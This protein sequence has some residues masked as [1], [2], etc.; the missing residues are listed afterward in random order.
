MSSINLNDYKLQIPYVQTIINDNMESGM[1]LSD[2]VA[3]LSAS[4]H[5]PL[6]ATYS[7]MALQMGNTPEIESTIESLKTF[8]HVKMV[9]PFEI[10]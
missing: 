5:L 2:A 9:V 6:I 4:I 10:T 1:T 8:Y 3:T 7:I